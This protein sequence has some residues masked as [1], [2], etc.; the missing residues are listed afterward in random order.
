MLIAEATQ[1][2]R[3]AV[4]E[5]VTC[6]PIDAAL[7]EPCRGLHDMRPAIRATAISA[8]SGLVSGHDD[9]RDQ[10]MWT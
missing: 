3:V 10:K 4:I 2:E 8:R 5:F 9:H 6:L 7:R 1:L